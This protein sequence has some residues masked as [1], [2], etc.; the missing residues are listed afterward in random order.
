MNFMS[1]FSAMNL[2]TEVFPDA[3]GPD[4]NKIHRWPCGKLRDLDLEMS[5]MLHCA[6]LLDSAVREQKIGEVGFIR[7]TGSSAN[8]DLR[9]RIMKQVR[10]EQFRVMWN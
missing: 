6:I 10:F 3:V 5:V 2:A 1:N 9:T 8:K 7:V 4:T